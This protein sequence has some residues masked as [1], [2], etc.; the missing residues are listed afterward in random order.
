MA[1]AC[2]ICSKKRNVGHNVSHAKNRTQH[3][4]KP[5]LHV[6]RMKLDGQTMKML[7]CT[8]CKRMVKAK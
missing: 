5:N 1:F 3:V 7:L 2:E 8:K 4:S 6:H